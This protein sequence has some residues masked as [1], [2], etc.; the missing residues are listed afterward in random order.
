MFSLRPNS[1]SIDVLKYDMVFNEH[2]VGGI[3]F[4]HKNS[5]LNLAFEGNVCYDVVSGWRGH[6]FAVQACQELRKLLPSDLRMLI[7]CDVSNVASRRVCEKV[8]ARFL[9]TVT[10]PTGGKR[11]RFVLT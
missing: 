3:E 6:G 5:P 11:N 7:F 10:L 8:G 9:G 2:V 1:D 4:R